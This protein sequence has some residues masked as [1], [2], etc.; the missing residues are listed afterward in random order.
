MQ[1]HNKEIL[2]IASDFDG[3]IIKPG[4]TNPP[5]LFFEAVEQL[6]AKKIPFI[7]ASGRQYANLRRI[8][9]PIADKIDYIAENGCLV[10]HQGK[11][12]HKSAID[13]SLAMELISDMKMQPGTEIMISGEN[14]GYTVTD[15]EEF[16]SMLRNKIQY[17]LTVINDY[18]EIP[19]D[20]IKMSIYWKTGI[21]GGPEKWFHEKYDGRLQVANGGNGWLDFNALGTGKGEALTVLA[22]HRNIPIE[23]IA[24]F[25]DNEN[26]ISMLKEAGI[27]YAVTSA[28]PHVKSVA[29]YVCDSVEEVLL[30]ALKES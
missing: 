4:E 14:I 27:S 21:P 12:I 20:I 1:L 22:Q 9:S 7:A 24:A 30:D 28:Y 26:D 19:E 11:V 10:V 3:T 17:N 8:L 29:D 5:A 15:N 6:F 13:R 25:G 2:A 23:K 18:E 16:L